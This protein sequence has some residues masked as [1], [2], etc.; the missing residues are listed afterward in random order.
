LAR[1]GKNH[2]PRYGTAMLLV[3]GVAADLDYLSYFGGPATFLRF[4]HTL[5]HSIV[6]SALVALTTAIIFFLLYRVTKSNDLTNRADAMRPELSAVFALLICLIG[7]ASHILLDLVSGI[8]VQLF[9]PFRAGWIGCELMTSLDPWILA[10]LSTALLLP[11]LL[12][13]VSEEIGEQKK[14]TRGRAA[15]IVAL[16][17]LVLYVGARAALH[18]QAVDLLSSR[19]YHA[20]P[21]LAS[22]A[23][24]LAATPFTWRGVVSTDATAEEL[25]VSLLPGREFDTDRSFVRYK[26]ESSPALDAGENTQ[27]AKAFLAYARVPFASVIR[28]EDGYI[29]ELRDLR[30]PPSDMSPENMVARVDFNRN[31]QIQDEGLRFASSKNP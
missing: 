20:R 27:V 26:P 3:S 17:I 16:A 28:K 23:F 1:A 25:Q 30:F 4:H 12:K 11:E 6:G 5:L 10:L 8:G 13:L 22:A 14:S 29:F 9:W 24:P 21:P 19:E 15:A 2:L 18:R 31:L 7:V